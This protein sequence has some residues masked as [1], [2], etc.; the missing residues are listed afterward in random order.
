MSKTLIYT[1]AGGDKGMGHVVRMGHLAKEL[2]KQG[3]TVG[4]I[5]DGVGETYIRKIGLSDCLHLSKLNNYNRVVVDVP[6]T[7]NNMLLDVGD[8]SQAVIVIVGTGWSITP[9]TRQI[10]DLIVY[11][12]IAEPSREVLQSAGG[13]VLWGLDWLILGSEYATV[14]HQR[15]DDYA[16]LYIGGGIPRDY[17]FEVYRCL[18]MFFDWVQVA[19]SDGQIFES[20]YTMQKNCSVFVTTFGV[21][22]YEAM[23][24]GKPVICFSRSSDHAE[25]ANQL[26]DYIT[27]VGLYDQAKPAIIAQLALAQSVL[28]L[29]TYESPLD[30]IGTERLVQFI[31]EEL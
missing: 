24:L 3:E 6:E 1:E 18:N 12:G 27:H 20:M 9:T 13:Y 7:D 30:G 15:Q 25:T 26:T 29:N 5:C 16:L 22:V 19:P 28:P 11:Q 4:I 2:L 23:R 17:A 8:G 14:A 21:T 31:L 10:A